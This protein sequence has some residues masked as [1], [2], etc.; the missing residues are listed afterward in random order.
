MKRAV[1]LT[2]LL[3]LLLASSTAGLAA[4][5]PAYEKPLRW[6]I[7]FWGPLRYAWSEKVEIST[8]PLWF[9]I[10]PNASIKWSHGTAC[11]WQ[12]LSQHGFFCPTWML[13]I[14]RRKGVG[15]ILSSEFE[16]PFL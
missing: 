4:F 16:I 1:C 9:L 8:H 5:E 12:I 10:L 13:R 15:G 14:L 2:A 7:G 3:W 11:G 6:E